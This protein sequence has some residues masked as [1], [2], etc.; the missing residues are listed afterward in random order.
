MSLAVTLPILG[1]AFWCVWATYCSPAPPEAVA[2]AP[3]PLKVVAPTFE[4]TVWP[5]TAMEAISRPFIHPVTTKE[6]VPELSAC[7]VSTME[8]IFELSVYTAM[9]KE[10]IREH[11]M[12]P[13]QEA[14]P[15]LN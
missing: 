13:V 4:L 15:E 5:V 3:A 10:A 2:S 8:T 12:L 11:S 7:P 1:L 14:D 9:A 6:A